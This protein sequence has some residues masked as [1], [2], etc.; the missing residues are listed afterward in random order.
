VSAAKRGAPDAPERRHSKRPRRAAASRGQDERRRLE[1][2]ARFLDGVAALRG[3]E[4]GSSVDP[5]DD[6]GSASASGSGSGSR[7]ARRS[8][9]GRSFGRE[10]VQASAAGDCYET[11]EELVR[12]LADLLPP[13]SAVWEPFVGSGRSTRALAAAGHRVARVAPDFFAERRPPLVGGQAPILVTNP[14]WSI[15]RDVFERLAAL[16]VERAAILVPIET[17]QT[18]YLHRWLAGRQLQLVVP[19]H[20]VRFYSGSRRLDRPFPHTVAWFCVGLGL[21]SDVVIAQ[22]ER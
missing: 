20:R 11:P 18:H 6:A 9:A 16:G 19:R 17:L 3:S 10:I 2:E 14:P 12:L 22:N 21:P 7:A 4:R 8:R 13:G 5:R 15:K 1:R